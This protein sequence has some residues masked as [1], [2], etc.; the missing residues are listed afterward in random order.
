MS[1]DLLNWMADWREVILAA[2]GLVLLVATIA[3]GFIKRSLLAAF[4]TLMFGALLWWG[5]ANSSWLRDRAGSD[6]DAAP[7]NVTIDVDVIE[8]R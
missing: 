5:M 8:A 1:Q 4:A 3:V 7:A 6:F 2:A